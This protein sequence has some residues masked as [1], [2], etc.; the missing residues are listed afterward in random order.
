MSKYSFYDLAIEI[1]KEAKYPL[2][3][4]EIWEEAQKNGCFKK[5]IS[6]KENN[7]T[8]TPIASLQAKIY[9]DLKKENS[10]FK[11]VSKRPTKFC[12]NSRINEFNSISR[13]CENSEVNENKKFK[14]RELHPLVVK[15]LYENSKFNLFSKTIFHEKSLR[16]KSG[17]NEWLHPDI[18]GV[19]FPF[20]DYEEESFELFR[21]LNQIKYKIYS[22]ELKVRLDFSNL[23]SAYFQ[24]VSNSSWAN[25]GYLITSEFDNEIIDELLRLNNAFGI[26]FIK[27]DVINLEN[28][29]VIIPAKENLNLD[30]KTIDLLVNKNKDFKDFIININKDIN[31]G[32]IHRI[33]L[34]FYDK[35]L[36]DDEIKKYLIDKK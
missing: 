3:A 12:L 25:F 10:S 34:K 26:G 9:L 22:F 27:I 35:I 11:I 2:T 23:R 4:S 31:I 1:L 28:S 17:E 36:K 6:F 15:F 33:G 8:K 24:A 13:D 5:L 14:E 7:L 20:K 32:D 19:H 21:N 16:A 29:K 18:V 30:Y